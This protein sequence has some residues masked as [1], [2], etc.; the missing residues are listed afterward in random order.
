MK[1]IKKFGRV[2]ESKGGST[3]RVGVAIHKIVDPQTNFLVAHFK[4]KLSRLVTLR[5]LKFTL[6]FVLLNLLRLLNR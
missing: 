4:K 5:V 1:F 2:V 3:K 6:Y